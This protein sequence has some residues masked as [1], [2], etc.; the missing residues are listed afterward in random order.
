LGYALDAL[1]ASLQQNCGFKECE[2]GN[3]AITPP[4]AGETHLPGT[5]LK[6]ASMGIMPLH[7]DA[8]E[9]GFLQL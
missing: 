5:G 8:G 1:Q 3:D 2:H 4:N 9:R 7:S 6:N